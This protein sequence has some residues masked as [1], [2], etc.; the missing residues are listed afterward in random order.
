MYLNPADGSGSG[1]TYNDG[2]LGVGATSSQGTPGSKLAVNGN[3]AIGSSYFQTA[4]PTDG[5]IIQGNVGIGT[6]SPASTLDVWGD[7]RVG[8]SSTPALFT[9]VSS[10]NVGIGTAAPGALLDITG[11]GELV[12]INGTGTNNSILRLQ[13]DGSIFRTESAG[14]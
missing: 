14:K 6:T 4:A 8:T 10:G 7:L 1:T 3:A 13:D 11:A 2:L 5:M 12:H 9:D